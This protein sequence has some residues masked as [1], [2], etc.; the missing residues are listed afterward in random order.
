MSCD[1][2]VRVQVNFT[3]I[4]KMEMFNFYVYVR[5]FDTLSLVC[6]QGSYATVKIHSKRSS[7]AGMKIKTAGYLLET[8]SF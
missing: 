4:N 6:T 2:Y 7:S 3:R 1:S 8:L 5:P